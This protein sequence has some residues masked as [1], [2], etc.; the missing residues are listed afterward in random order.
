MELHLRDARRSDMGGDYG[1]IQLAEIQASLKAG[2]VWLVKDSSSR[3][4]VKE[5]SLRQ[6]L[7]WVTGAVFTDRR[8]RGPRGCR[9][10]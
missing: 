6:F 10:R 1:G 8:A 2:Y 7:V 5:N 4:D 3:W 9:F